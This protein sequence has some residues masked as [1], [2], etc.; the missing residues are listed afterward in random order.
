MRPEPVG[1]DHNIPLPGQKKLEL[2][3]VLL[4]HNIPP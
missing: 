1:R 4:R 2:H 3:P